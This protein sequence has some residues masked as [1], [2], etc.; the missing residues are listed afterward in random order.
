VLSPSATPAEAG[1]DLV[2]ERRFS[3]LVH[4]I[5][6]RIALIG[7][8]HFRPHALNHYS[9][10]ILVLL[11]EHGT[12]RAGELVDLMLLPQ[13]TLSTQL[14]EL[15]KRRLISRR[16]SRSDNRAVIVSLTEQGRVVAADCNALSRRVQAIL[17]DS[18]TDTEQRA[19][20]RVLA[21]IDESLARIQDETLVDFHGPA[22][23][24]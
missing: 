2:L 10:R 22:A 18:L 8:R 4:R 19:A 3:Y 16:R 24:A 11:L 7:N 5:S 9:A 13:S 6:A 21:K 20:R 14:R 12:L 1:E 23:D 17:V 15:Q